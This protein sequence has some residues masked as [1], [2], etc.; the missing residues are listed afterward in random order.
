MSN[1]TQNKTTANLVLIGLTAVALYLC[2]LLFRPFAGPIL[3]AGVVAIVFHPLHRYSRRFLRNSNAAALASTLLALL[4]TAVPLGLIITMA[5]R[6]L[7]GQYQSLTARAGEGGIL[8]YVIHGLEQVAGWFSRQFGLPAPDVRAVVMR[9]MGEASASLV[10]LGASLVTNVF[11]W[12]AAAV[13]AFVVLFFLFRDGERG[14]AQASAMLPMPEDR[15]ADLRARISNTV[16]ANF[17]GGVAVGGIQGTLT[18]LAFWALGLDAPLL[19]G[20]VTGICSLVPMV[21]SALVWAPAG[22]VLLLTGHLWKGLILLAW[23]AGVVGIADNIVRPLIVSERVRLHTL[24]VFFALLGGIQVFGVMGLFVGPV[25]V[26]I[27]TAL[28]GML[29]QDLAARQSATE[30]ESEVI[31]M[32]KGAAK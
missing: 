25:I 26:S 31:Q 10:R 12:V 28:L 9:R 15:A 20:L 19:W 32:P 13:I 18:A 23:G 11:S 30:P 17:Y 8:A 2:Y 4:L 21:G 14:I 24:Y 29:R 16:V 22:V 5:S 27:A 6:E 3:F 1:V 7:S